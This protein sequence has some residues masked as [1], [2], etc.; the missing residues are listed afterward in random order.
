LLTK[1]ENINVTNFIHQ[2]DKTKTYTLPVGQN[3]S[4]RN[5]NRL[6]ST[7]LFALLVWSSISAEVLVS[8]N[9][10]N[11]VISGQIFR[12]VYKDEYFLS[13]RFRV[14]KGNAQNQEISSRIS[15]I[16]SWKH[17]ARILDEQEEDD[18][19]LNTPLRIV[20]EPYV[21]YFFPVLKPFSS[22]EI[23]TILNAME[24]SLYEYLRAR[25]SYHLPTETVLDLV[26]IGNVDSK[27]YTPRNSSSSAYKFENSNSLYIERAIVSFRETN[28]TSLESINEDDVNSW[29][30][31]AL[32]GTD[33]ASFLRNFILQQGQDVPKS[34]EVIEG[35]IYEFPNASSIFDSNDAT[36]TTAP[37]PAV[38]VAIVETPPTTDKNQRAPEVIVPSVVVGM[39]VFS[40]LSFFLLKKR[41]T[42]RDTETDGG[43]ISYNSMAGGARKTPPGSPG[44]VTVDANDSMDEDEPTIT[45]APSPPPIAMR[46]PRRSIVDSESEFTVST[47]TNDTTVL[48][49]IHN[50][51]HAGGISETSAIGDDPNITT[52]PSSYHNNKHTSSHAYQIA[53]TESFEMERHITVR[54]DMLTNSWMGGRNEKAKCL[55]AEKLQI[56][57][58]SNIQNESVLQPSYFSAAEE[59]MI[60][61]MSAKSAAA[62]RKKKRDEKG[63]ISSIDD[64]SNSS[65]SDASSRSSGSTPLPESASDDSSFSTTD[66]TAS[67]NTPASAFVVRIPNKNQ[68]W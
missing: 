37:S 3:I 14:R 20:V 22:I 38:V 65:N 34:F 8:A 18:D 40:A 46:T 56:A 57:N 39:V 9:E 44:G 11:K 26:R 41:R 59:R 47:E 7:T 27:F 63:D 2:F 53:I 36:E 24:Y 48:K 54:K 4:M 49:T 5:R 12:D 55:S 43:S 23:D 28:P 6:I 66:T 67:I 17:G 32:L 42:K 19:G 25:H 58:A 16:P 61:K 13:N 10:R 30:R 62:E 29:I 1:K 15:L 21:A 45:R 31:E 50:L 51:G 60:R 35:V 68:I 64:N 52:S 33:F